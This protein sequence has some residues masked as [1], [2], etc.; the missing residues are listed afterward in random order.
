ML[1]QQVITQEKL[2]SVLS[3]INTNSLLQNP[4]I[5]SKHREIT[6]TQGLGKAQEYLQ[7]EFFK[8]SSE[9]HVQEY[10]AQKG[11]EEGLQYS[12]ERINK[13]LEVL[14]NLNPTQDIKGTVH[15]TPEEAVKSNTNIEEEEKLL[16]MKL[17]KMRFIVMKNSNLI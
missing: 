4:E 3:K 12:I 16:I 17:L 7:E 8:Q 5:L 1:K 13:D 2:Q 14:E 15:S 11:K 10:L 6:D 9:S